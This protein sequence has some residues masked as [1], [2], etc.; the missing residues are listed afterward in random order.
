MTKISI[1]IPVYNVERFLPRCLD[2]LV[3]Q[4]LHET[5]IICVDDGSTD[6]SPAILREYAARDS[7]IK[8]ITQ[9]NKRQ[10]GAR[11]TCFDAAC[12]EWVAFIDS[13]DW[14]DADYFERL[15][16]AA[17]RHDADIACACFSKER[18]RLHRWVVR[19]TR[20][21]QFD[22]LQ[23][24]FRACHCPPDFYVTNKLYRRE[25]LQEAG[26][27]FAEHVQYEDVE[28][29]AEALI[30]LGRLVTVPDAVYHYVVHGGST[31]KSRQTAAKQAQ[32]Y[33]AHKAFIALADR[34]GIEVGGR[35]RD[36]TMRDYGAGGISLLKVKDNGKRLSYRLFDAV[37]IW[38][39][40]NKE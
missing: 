38:T 8:V 21:E 22:D 18:G 31:V 20:E 12:G 34:H 3:G 35:F 2:S 28:Y 40:H 33:R 30:A 29:L 26:V 23:A 24:K 7:R 11:N 6:R 32:K 19:Y 1:I 13:D 16:D 36:V 5:E 14:V 15:M 27:R 37:P 25:R 17:V 10:G 4:T 39:K 9:R